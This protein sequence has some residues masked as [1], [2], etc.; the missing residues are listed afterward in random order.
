MSV[1]Q[2][3][4]VLAGLWRGA[5]GVLAAW[6]V[7]ITTLTPPTQ[8][9]TRAGGGG[10]S[11]GRRV[12]RLSSGRAENVPAAAVSAYG[13]ILLFLPLAVTTAV[14]LACTCT[15]EPQL[16]V[17]LEFPPPARTERFV[18]CCSSSSSITQTVVS[19]WG[20]RK[21]PTGRECCTC[22]QPFPSSFIV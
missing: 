17:P 8:A 1:R 4:A 18:S 7:L 21:H 2:C 22:S 20:R 11:G 12:K 3:S 5:A 10:T 19:L 15:T 9:P 6:P 13:D 14:Y 16:S